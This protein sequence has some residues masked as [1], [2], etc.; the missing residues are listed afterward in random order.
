YGGLDLGGTARPGLG[1]A[2]GVLAVAY[3]FDCSPTQARSAAKDTRSEPPMR[4]TPG[5]WPLAMSSY[6]FDRPIPRS[7]ATSIGRTSSGS[8]TTFERL[9]SPRT[10]N[11]LHPSIERMALVVNLLE[12]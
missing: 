5:I 4:T 8:R 12:R 7:W 9:P 3:H 6:A 10:T 11:T 2:V 1:A